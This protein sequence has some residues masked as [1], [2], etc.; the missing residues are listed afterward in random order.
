MSHFLNPQGLPE[1]ICLALI[2]VYIELGTPCFRMLAYKLDIV[3]PNDIIITA[4]VDVCWNPSYTGSPEPGLILKIFK[5][6]LN[7]L[8]KWR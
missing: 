1:I 4:D 8:L 6:M 2:Y 7:L 3:S 5:N